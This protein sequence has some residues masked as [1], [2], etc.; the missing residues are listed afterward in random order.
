MI[1]ARG[2]TAIVLLC[3]LCSAGSVHGAQMG[4]GGSVR[5]CWWEPYWS[6]VSDTLVL[7]PIKLKSDF[8]GG[9]LLSIGINE[10]WGIVTSYTYGVYRGTVTRLLLNPLYYYIEQPVTTKREAKRHDVDFLVSGR[11]NEYVNIFGGVAYS[12]YYM[13]TNASVL[14]YSY[15]HRI[16][17]HFA[18][19]EIGAGFTI[20]L[21]STL[22][23]LPVVSCVFQFSRF[24]AGRRNP[25]SDIINTAVMGTGTTL[26]YAGLDLAL[27]LAYHIRQINMTIALGGRFRYLWITD[28]DKGGF[29]A[30]DRHDMYGG[31]N[32]LVVYSFSLTASR[33]GEKDGPAL[34]PQLL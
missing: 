11:V 25:V 8:S 15:S 12:G 3:L 30:N 19:P 21:V 22:C 26:L 31:I 34:P 5:Y 32:L 9:P 1:M 17:H 13:Y 18:G 29:V 20:P 33:A 7:P 10:T 4:I 27:S 6:Q 24:T 2:G 23:L 16:F 14:F 28:I